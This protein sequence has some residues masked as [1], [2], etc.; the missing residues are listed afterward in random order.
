MASRNSPTTPES[1]DN[2]ESAFSSHCHNG[3]RR[4][5]HHSRSTKSKSSSS[6]SITDDPYVPLQ[7]FND[8]DNNCSVSMN[9]AIR[10][11]DGL[12]HVPFMPHW[13]Q[14]L[15]SQ[16]C[17]LREYIRKERAAKGLPPLSC[18]RIPYNE[19]VENVRRMQEREKTHNEHRDKARAAADA[20]SLETASN[21]VS[22]FLKDRTNLD[23]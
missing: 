23:F 21:N 4:K 6:S 3:E 16:M 19:T 17:K 12:A 8:M 11:R 14:Q 22:T 7:S 10:F 13:Q 15:S 9:R 1:I 18:N 20:L 5:F 2:T